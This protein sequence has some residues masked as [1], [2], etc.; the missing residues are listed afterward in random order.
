MET[1]ELGPPAPGVRFPVALVGAG[2]LLLGGAVLAGRGI[3]PAAGFLA[4]ISAV[5]VAYK[6]RVR[7]DLLVAL[8]LLVVLVIPIKRYQF[9][10][11]LP[12]DLEPYRIVIAILLGIW[13]TALLV[14]PSVRLRASALDGPLMLIGLSVIASVT[15]NPGWITN[16][17]ILGSYV[18]PTW[19]GLVQDPSRLPFADVTNDV[20]KALLF[21]A[22]FYLVFYFIVS[23]VRTPRQIHAVVK[24][25]VVATAGV[26]LFAIV[27]RRTDYNVFNHLQGWIPLVEFQGGLEAEGIARGGRLR[28]YGSAQHP[29]ALAALFAMVLPLSV[30]LA[31][32]ARRILWYLTTTLMALALLATVS[33]TGIVMLAAIGVVFLVL[34]RDVLKRAWLLVLPAFVVVHLLMPGTIGSFRSAFLPPQGIGSEQTEFAGRISSERVGPQFAVIK[35]K[36]AFGQGYG[37]RVTTG[38]DQNSRILDNQW[39]ATAVETGLVGVFGW[40]WL[41]VRFIRRAGREAKRDLSE[42]GWLLTALAA[43][44]AGFAV[45]MLTYDAFAFIQATLVFFVL[46]AIGAST[47]AYEGAWESPGGGDAASGSRRRASEIRGSAR[48]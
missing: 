39:L 20:T 22:S 19:T 5:A 32:Q 13:A 38:P 10:V 25:L 9:A 44:A 36:P 11:S 43:A 2:V 42:R 45:A 48:A 31:Y 46:L 21:F 35:E 6:L 24:T 15:L 33:R 16:F 7:W 1:V 28:V 34:R 30:Y 26:A 37:T 3:A 41:F 18:G 47:L 12:F 23:V 40:L 17:N 4:L 8:V 29:I 27:E 14:D